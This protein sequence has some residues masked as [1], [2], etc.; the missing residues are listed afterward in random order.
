MLQFRAS[1]VGKLMAYPD[2]NSLPVGAISHIQE[3]ASQIILDWQPKLD[4]HVIEKGRACEQDAIDLLNEVFGKSYQKNKERITTD[5]LTGEWDIFCELQNLIIDIKNAYSKKTFPM[6][7]KD[8]DKKLYEWQ[9]VAYMHLK[10]AGHAQVAYCLV[11]TPEELISMRDDPDWHLV[12][13]IP[14]ELRVTTFNMERNI[15]KE[16]QL[17][18]RVKLAQDK[19]KEM[20][21][22]K[23][24]S[25][26][27]LEVNF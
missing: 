22:D 10:N 12:S 13:Y 24:F 1:G 3:L 9:L 17:L 25:H 26:E 11:D 8:G 2:K 23:G 20:L 19:L 16:E 5:L 7:L 4:M 21:A 14:P 15:E 18:A 27:N 6:F